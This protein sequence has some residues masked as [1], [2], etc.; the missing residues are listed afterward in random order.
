MWDL[1]GHMEDNLGRAAWLAVLSVGASVVVSAV[2]A[3]SGGNSSLGVLVAFAGF[4]FVGWY[5][6]KA[7]KAQ[8]RSPFLYGLISVIPPL[9]L[10]A[11]T[12]LSNRDMEIRLSR[13]DSR[14]D[15]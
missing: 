12:L 3:W 6:G 9:A 2:L 15:A 10:F 4:V 7:A 14:H 11:F 8:G 5:M 13:Q 1:F